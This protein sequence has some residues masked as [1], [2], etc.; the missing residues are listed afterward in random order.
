MT[1]LFHNHHEI[2]VLVLLETGAARYV[3]ALLII[4]TKP[5]KL[6]I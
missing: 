5:Q 6:P 3:C 4:F 2:Q 1:E